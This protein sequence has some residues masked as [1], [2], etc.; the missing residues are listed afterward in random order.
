VSHWFEDRLRAAARILTPSQAGAKKAAGIFAMIDPRFEFEA[1]GSRFLRRPSKAR[2]IFDRAVALS[3]EGQPDPQTIAGLVTG[4]SRLELEL[5]HG[6]V[7]EEWNRH[8]AIATIKTSFSSHFPRSEAQ[9]SLTALAALA[10]SFDFNCQA[11]ALQ[12]ECLAD[13]ATIASIDRPFVGEILLPTIQSLVAQLSLFRHGNAGLIEFGGGQVDPNLAS[14]LS[15]Q[16]HGA[17]NRAG[18]FGRVDWE[19]FGVACTVWMGPAGQ[20]VPA[21]ELWV[22]N[23]PLL[24]TAPAGKFATCRTL[25]PPIDMHELSLRRRDTEVQYTLEGQCRAAGKKPGTGMQW[26]RT[27][28]VSLVDSGLYGEDWMLPDRG[29]TTAPTPRSRL[30]FV[31]GEGVDIE[32]AS[33][34]VWYLGAGSGPRW[35]LDAPGHTL[36]WTPGETLGL[37][38]VDAGRPPRVAERLSWS[39]IP[40]VD[41]PTLPSRN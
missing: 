38:Q 6:G 19:A 1:G 31:I 18:T 24:T 25:D 40:F 21:L 5:R 4:C 39:L 27:L 9:R 32:R 37:L 11:P 30:T 35:R 10:A 12:L 17:L 13:L 26:G 2:E 20:K 28:K 22:E 14:R 34:G 33:G 3:C 16:A 8:L 15:A 41:L 36:S 23:Q 7:E 29:N